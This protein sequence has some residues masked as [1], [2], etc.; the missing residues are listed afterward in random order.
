MNALERQ[1]FRNYLISNGDAIHPDN[2]RQFTTYCRR[3]RGEAVHPATRRFWRSYRQDAAAISH[4]A[5]D[6]QYYRHI[7][8][9][10]EG[11]E[12]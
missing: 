7:E 3:Q 4:T 12:Q 1:A 8:G 10:N 2:A 5:N 11:E 6:D 9:V